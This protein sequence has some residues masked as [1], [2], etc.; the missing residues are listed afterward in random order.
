[1]ISKQLR[2]FEMLNTTTQSIFE[3]NDLNVL[4]ILKDGSNLTSWDYV[5][6]KD[7]I[8]YITEDLFGQTN[9]AN[10]YAGLTSLKAIIVFGFGD[11]DNME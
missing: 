8:V 11:V 4:I 3:L 2:E 10:R 1:M 5:D 9:L 7:D 6:D